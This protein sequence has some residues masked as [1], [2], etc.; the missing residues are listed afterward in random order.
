MKIFRDSQ[1]A[2]LWLMSN[3]FTHHLEDEFGNSF[4]H[5]NQEKNTII[6]EYWGD[7]GEGVLEMYDVNKMS[8]EEFIE[9]YDGVLLFGVKNI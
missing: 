4:C 7:E 5:D 8:Y 1:Y 9:D 2:L 3:R 6:I